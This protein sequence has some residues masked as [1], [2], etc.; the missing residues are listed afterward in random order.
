MRRL[1]FILPLSVH[2]YDVGCKEAKRRGYNIIVGGLLGL[3]EIMD[4][5]IDIDNVTELYYL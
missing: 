2:V 4:N 5:T 3:S 1:R